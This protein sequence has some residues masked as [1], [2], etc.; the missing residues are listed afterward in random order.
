MSSLKKHISKCIDIDQISLNKIYGHVGGAKALFEVF[1]KLEADNLIHVPEFFRTHPLSKNRIENIKQTAIQN[2]WQT[3]GEM[4]A[5]PDRFD[6]W[7]SV[8]VD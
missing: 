8:T 7:M 4:T 3:D 2:G 1:D 5:F 6:E